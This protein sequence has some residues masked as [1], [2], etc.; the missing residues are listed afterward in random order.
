MTLQ[1]S[2]RFL[3]ENIQQHRVHFQCRLFVFGG[4]R[5]LFEREY[6][7]IRV[8]V[9][10]GVRAGDQQA[11]VAVRLGADLELLDELRHG[12]RRPHDEIRPS[13]VCEPVCG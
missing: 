8:A 11:D 7:R 5:R 3:G 10:K 2:G 13:A 6:G 9:G 4:S 12:A 1:V